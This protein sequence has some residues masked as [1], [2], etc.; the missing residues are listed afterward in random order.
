VLAIAADQRRAHPGA[1][2]PTSRD[3]EP[4]EGDVDP[5]HALPAT[6][7]GQHEIGGP[8]ADVEPPATGR[9]AGRGAGEPLGR[10]WLG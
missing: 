2:Q 7:A 10:T 8:T 5:D 1:L 4:S 6:Q 3:D 9:L